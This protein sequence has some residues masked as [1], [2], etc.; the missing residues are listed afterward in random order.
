MEEDNLILGWDSWYDSIDP[1]NPLYRMTLPLVDKNLP[2]S[3]SQDPTWVVNRHYY[4]RYCIF[5]R[6]FSKVNYSC[7]MVRPVLQSSWHSWD[8]MCL[9]HLA[10]WRLVIKS[11][12]A[13]VPTII[14]WPANPP[15]WLN[16][17]RHPRSFVK[18]RH[19][20]W[21]FWMSL[22]V[23]HRHLTDMPLPM[24]CCIILPPTLVVWVFSLH[25]TILCAKNLNS[26]LRSKTCTCKLN[27]IGAYSRLSYPTFF[28]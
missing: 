3:Y 13:L 26:T 9:P 24:L 5:N 10:D 6:G 22:V 23:A 19:G 27:M 7:E 16:F 21:W 15:L 28:K 1:V 12:H 2:S 17:K 11:L 20:R 8:A 25:T 14:S 18:P 4:D